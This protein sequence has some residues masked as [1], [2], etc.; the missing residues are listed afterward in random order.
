MPLDRL[1]FVD[2]QNRVRLCYNV[3]RTAGTELIQLHV[4]APHVLTSGIEC[5]RVDNHDI[6][7]AV[8]RKAVNFC[9]L[10]RIIDEEPDFLAVFLC[11]ML[12]CYLKGFINVLADGDARHDHD[13]LAPAVVLVQLVHGFDIGIGLAD[14]GLH[15]NRQVVT[16]FQLV[17]RLELIGSLHL[18][19]M[20][21][22]QFVG[23]LRHDALI[24][25]AGEIRIV[26]H[27]LLTIA[28]VYHIGGCEVRL[29]GKDVNDCFRRIRLK[30]LM[31]ELQL[32]NR[33]PLLFFLIIFIFMVLQFLRFSRN[34]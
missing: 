10:G 28:S 1:R 11:K 8:R 31:F 23:K 16:T 24:A 19:Q 27:G 33:C 32:H 21:Q 22:N 20:L 15:F 4:N 7:G 6:D 26:R 29:S 34:F 5:L 14:A 17:R 3:N 2:N 25:P 9:E 18:L 12:L 13:E 30:F